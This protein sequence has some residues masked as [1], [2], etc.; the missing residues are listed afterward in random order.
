MMSA[1][2]EMPQTWNRYSYVLN[3]PLALIDPTGKYW[4]Y[5]G[6][7][8]QYQG[9]GDPTEEDRK[10]WKRLGYQII[11][12]G[13]LFN[14]ERGWGKYE[15][16]SGYQVR[17]EGSGNIDAVGLIPKSN[18]DLPN[19]SGEV[20]MVLLQFE[21]ISING[22][23]F[24]ISGGVAPTILNA[25]GAAIYLVLRPGEEDSQ[26]AI[27]ATTRQLNG[28]ELTVDQALT[29]GE[30]WLGEN[31]KEIAPGVYRS[32]DGTRQ[33]RMTNNDLMDPKQGPH[34]H[35]EYIGPN[36]RTITENSHV[37]L[38]GKP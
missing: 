21:I 18:S 30:K 1:V 37:R 34:V 31:Y 32:A 9:E 12:D 7:D 23:L 2:L 15:K 29:Q 13:S 33:F 28:G 27:A 8:L 38:R 35:F 6:S 4:V 17:L 20:G 26:E 10:K 16:F 3:N 36:G 25:T 22:A 11:R 14:I 5:N 24:I 19:K